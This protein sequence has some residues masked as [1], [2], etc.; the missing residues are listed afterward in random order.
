MQ[1][2]YTTTLSFFKIHCVVYQAFT[3][4]KTQKMAK[5]NYFWGSKLQVGLIFFS[6]VAEVPSQNS[7]NN[8]ITY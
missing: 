1:A 7:T 8:G 6:L 2:P 3:Q 5:N 4:L